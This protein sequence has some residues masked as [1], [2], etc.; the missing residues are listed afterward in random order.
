M[1]FITYSQEIM[2][3]SFGLGVLLVC[4]ALAW[5]VFSAVSILRDVRRVIEKIKTTLAV[6]HEVSTAAKQKVHDFSIQFKAISSGLT[7]VLDWVDKRKQEH[8]SDTK[9]KDKEE[10]KKT[11]ESV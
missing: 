6:I 4:V 3:L 2:H 1:F 5:L 9:N 7:T 11:G 10:V 8:A